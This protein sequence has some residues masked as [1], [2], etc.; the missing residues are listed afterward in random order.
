MNRLLALSIVLLLVPALSAQETILDF[1]SVLDVRKNGDLEVTETIRVRSEGIRIKRGIYRDFPTLYR[2][3][4]GLKQRVPFEVLAITRDGKAEAWRSE[5]QSNGIRLYIG[6]SDVLLP[7]GQYTYSIKYRTGCQLGFFEDFDELYW[8]VTGNGWAFPIEKASAL[9][10]LPPGARS[11][12]TDAYTGASGDKGKDWREEPRLPAGIFFETTREL[13][14]GEGLTI[15]VAWPKGF[16]TKP[17]GSDGWQALAKDNPG[18]ALGI[19]GL[20]VAAVYFVSAWL[21]VGRD[22]PGGVIIPR[23]APPKDF[24]PAAVRYLQ[25]MGRF[26]DRSVAATLID[27]AVHGTVKIH[28][29]GG[30]YEVLR[31]EKKPTGPASLAL[32]SNLVGTSNRVALKQANHSRIRKARTELAKAVAAQCDSVYFVKNLRLWV[33]GLVVTLIPLAVSLFDAKEPGGALFLCIW[34]GFWSFGVAMLSMKIVSAWRYAGWR[35]IAAIP[36]LIFSIPFFAGW[37]FGAA[38]LVVTASPWVAGCYVAGIVLTMIFHHLLKRPTEAGRVALDEIEGFRLYLS[39]AESDRLDLEHPPTRTPVLFEKFLPYALALG[40]EQQWSEQF[41]E[42]ITTA[43]FSPDW[44]QG[45]A[46]S[47]AGMAG[48]TT[49]M[50]SSLTSAISSSST[51]PGSSSGSSGGG[52]SGGGGGGGGGGGW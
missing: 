27:L 36:I 43:S 29:A 2:G 17:A 19:I 49:G 5:P 32:F 15:A 3:P 37:V 16:V 12:R 24:G 50:A 38:M 48:F 6:E 14:P 35:K 51:V 40:V 42:I 45:A 10:N 25:G 9:V 20:V 23:F 31:G 47:A 39:V 8:N 33:V 30:S 18:V 4:L 22:P 44:Y 28:E 7:P 34:L 21:A 11:L 41:S 13:S 26:D 52:S 1:A 46:F